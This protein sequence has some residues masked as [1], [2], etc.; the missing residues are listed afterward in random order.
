MTNRGVLQVCD[1]C[2]TGRSPSQCGD[3]PDADKLATD[4]SQ[5]EERRLKLLQFLSAN[6]Q[7]IENDGLRHLAFVVNL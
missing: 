4:Q 7:A 3:S 6:V 5:G 2:E 1:L